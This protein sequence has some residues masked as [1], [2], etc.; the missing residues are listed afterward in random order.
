[1]TAQKLNI[2]IK[3]LNLKADKLEEQAHRLWKAGNNVKSMRCFKEIESLVS[4][5]ELLETLILI[6]KL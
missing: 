4:R 3:N 1:M 5:I 2:K 6:E